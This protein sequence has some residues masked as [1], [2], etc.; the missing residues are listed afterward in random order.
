[1]LYQI[2]HNMKPMNEAS[3]IIDVLLTTTTEYRADVI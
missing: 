2:T 3:D 1:M